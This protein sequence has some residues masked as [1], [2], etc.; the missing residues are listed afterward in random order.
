[1]STT[2]GTR[3]SEASGSIVTFTVREDRVA[4]LEE[5]EG[6]DHPRRFFWIAGSRCWGPIHQERNGPRAFDVPR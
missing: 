1:M 2:E 6:A 5:D 3:T 4:K